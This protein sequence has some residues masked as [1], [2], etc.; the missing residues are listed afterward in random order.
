MQ[1]TGVHIIPDVDHPKMRSKPLKKTLLIEKTSSISML[2][3]SSDNSYFL[4][5]VIHQLSLV[6]LFQLSYLQNDYSIHSTF[7]AT[8]NSFYILSSLILFLTCFSFCHILML[9]VYPH[10]LFPSAA[11]SL[12]SASAN[13]SAPVF[14]IVLLHRLRTRTRVW[15]W[16]QGSL[17]KPVRPLFTWYFNSFLCDATAAI[18]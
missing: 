7:P 1:I 3:T 4:F 12:P 15:N 16:T 8:L 10:V 6:V 14:P 11:W 9:V 5:W 13:P 18:H 17:T 2:L